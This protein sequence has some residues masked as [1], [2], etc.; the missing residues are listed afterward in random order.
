MNFG[1]QNRVEKYLKNENLKIAYAY[2]IIFSILYICDSIYTV[3]W[4]R[5]DHAIEITTDILMCIPFFFLQRQN[6]IRLFKCWG[7]L[8]VLICVFT[9]FSGLPQ[10]EIFYLLGL[11][12]RVVSV[13]IFITWSAEN[14]I[15]IFKASANTIFVIACFFLICYIGFDLGVLGIEGKIISINIP[16]GTSFKSTDFTCFCNFYFRWDN[17]ARP[18]LGMP[19]TRANGFFRECGEYQIFL[20]FALLYY[21][22]IEQE[23]R[24][25]IKEIILVLSVISTASTMGILILLCL[26]VLKIMRQCKKTKMPSWVF[27]VICAVLAI[28]ALLVL[29]EKF[30]NGVVS[31][32]NNL[33]H[34]L[35]LIKA[36]WVVGNGYAREYK[37]F[38]G[39]LN[40]FVHF[41]LLGVLPVYIYIR[42]LLH[43]AFNTDIWGNFALFV[44]WCSSLLNE[45]YGY[46]MF[47]IAI[48]LLCL[49]NIK[50]R[51][52]RIK[53]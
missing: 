7:G 42:G 47:F 43:N 25:L 6:I 15:D 13:S 18:V 50:I 26:G 41:G 32:S 44:W 20:N 28:M 39:L 31:R 29:K 51:T 16:T 1:G 19:I 34:A 4:F 2:F 14:K 40:Y 23:K 46:D 37:T 9:L 12:I 49:V 5:Y 24:N 53:E 27:I 10:G 11:I 48:Y 30:S 8:S 22:F 3:I 52:E 35:D 36:H 38:Y 33:Q 45:A 17:V 21:W